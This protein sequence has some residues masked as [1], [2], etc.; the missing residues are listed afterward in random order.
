MVKKW[1]PHD[2]VY[3]NQCYNKVCYKGI[4]LY[5][6]IYYFICVYLFFSL[7]TALYSKKNIAEHIVSA[8]LTLYSG[9][10]STTMVNC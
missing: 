3:Q 6:C 9:F 8:L 2:Y 4:A 1:E 5:T 10:I 7:K